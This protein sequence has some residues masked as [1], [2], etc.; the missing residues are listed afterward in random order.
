MWDLQQDFK[1]E[2]DFSL[3]ETHNNKQQSVRKNVLFLCRFLSIILSDTNL[4]IKGR[5]LQMECVNG[6]AQY[7]H[8]VLLYWHMVDHT[9]LQ[10]AGDWPPE[11]FRLR[12]FSLT[13]LLWFRRIRSFCSSTVIFDFTSAG[14]TA[15]FGRSCEKVW[16]TNA[17]QSQSQ[18][19]LVVPFETFCRWID[20]NT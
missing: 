7:K 12:L 16:H 9:T 14:N 10:L 17:F 13:E 11:R 5:R 2:R 4:T 18:W 19:K 3:S 20:S 6:H 15:L 8:M 1:Q